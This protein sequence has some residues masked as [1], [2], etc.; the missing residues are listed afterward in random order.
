M[1]K[2]KINIDN[3]EYTLA[4][5]RNSIK[6]LESRNFSVDNFLTKSL[7]YYDILWAS[8]FLVYHPEINLE[9]AIELLDNYEKSGKKAHQYIKFAIDEYNSFINALADISSKENELEIIED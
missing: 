3:K 4:M 2:T 8:L 5:N 7:T 1:R 6:W 9:K